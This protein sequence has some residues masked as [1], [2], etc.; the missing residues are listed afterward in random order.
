MQ[1]STRTCVLCSLCTLLQ[2]PSRL[3]WVKCLFDVYGCRMPW[4]ATLCMWRKYPVRKFWNGLKI[5]V[6]KMVFPIN[7][8]HIKGMFMKL[9]LDHRP[10]SWIWTSVQHY[11][12]WWQNPTIG[13]W[14]RGGSRWN[15]LLV[16]F[17][18]SRVG[19]GWPAFTFWPLNLSKK[20]IIALVVITRNNISTIMIVIF[21]LNDYEVLCMQI[22]LW[23]C[24]II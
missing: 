1:N 22:R 15:R 3:N 7:A 8:N 23:M 20:I 11:I 19:L 18:T 10:N 13:S 21:H 4:L 9:S 2:L 12:L 16:D 14:V 24:S 17:E 6:G 5:S